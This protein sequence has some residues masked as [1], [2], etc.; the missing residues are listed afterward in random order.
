M[1]KIDSKSQ[2]RRTGGRTWLGADSTPTNL[3]VLRW[4]RVVFPNHLAQTSHDRLVVSS[5]LVSDWVHTSAKM[6]CLP[7]LDIKIVERYFPFACPRHRA[8]KPI[9]KSTSSHPTE[10]ALRSPLRQRLRS[11]YYCSRR[12]TLLRR[13]ALRRL[14]Q[15]NFKDV[16]LHSCCP[17]HQSIPAWP[18]SS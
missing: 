14:P 15:Y 10:V 1:D 16:T 4:R 11:T 7:Y 6:Y 9:I 17:P 3:A 12:R 8:G 5:S 2:N 18:L 13:Q